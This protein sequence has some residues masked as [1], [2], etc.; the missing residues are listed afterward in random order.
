MAEQTPIG[1][2]T[3]L[4]QEESNC[5]ACQRPDSAD[6]MVQCD[7]CDG[8][9]HYT[10]AGVDASVMNRSWVCGD[11]TSMQED[12]I[13][14]KSGSSRASAASALSVCMS[15]LVERQQLERKRAEIELQ[16]RHL[17]EQQKLIDKVLEGEENGSHRSGVSARSGTIEAAS[18]TS[19]KRLSTPLPP[20]APLASSV[21]RSV[22][23]PGTPRSVAPPMVTIPLAVLKPSASQLPQGTKSEDALLELRNR[24]EQCERR[25]KPTHE[26]LSALQAQL[27]LCR[28]ILEGFQ[29]SAEMCE[30]VGQ[31]EASSTVTEQLPKPAAS[32]PRMEKQTGAIPKA[33]RTLATVP[34]DERIRSKNG[35]EADA[36]GGIDPMNRR[37]PVR[38]PVSHTS[39]AA[40]SQTI[41]ATES[42]PSYMETP[43]KRQALSNYS[44]NANEY[45]SQYCPTTNMY[46]ISREQS[47]NFAHP[48]NSKIPPEVPRE[49]QQVFHAR[50][51]V[52]QIL[53]L[54]KSQYKNK[55][56]ER[57]RDSPT[58]PVEFNKFPLPPRLSENVYQDQVIPPRAPGGPTQQ[59]LA[60]RQSLAKELPRFSGDPA[61]WPIF[62]SSYRYTTEACGFSDGENMLRLQRCLSGSALETV[63][64]RLVLPAAVPQ[65]IETL[66]MRFGRPELLI[67][68]LLR[69]VRD[70]PAPRSDR[71]EG[72]IDFGMA[73]QALCDHIEAANER[74]HLSNPSLLQELVAKLPA[75]QRMMWAGYKRSFQVVDLKTFGDYMTSVVQDASSVVTFEPES[76][77][78]N[79]CDR[80]KNK[81]FVNTHA[82][83]GAVSSVRSINVPTGAAKQ[84]DCAHCSKTGHR[85]RECI[86]F[87]AL[88]VDD[89]WRR[90][91]A[92]GLCQ[93]C[94]FSHGRRACRIRSSCDIEGCQFRH[95]PLL[96]SLRGPPKAPASNALV[97][98][99]HTHRLLTSSTLFR[100]IPVILHGSD[101]SIDTFAFLDEGSDLTLMEHD[102]A[103]SLGLK[104]SPQPLCLRWTGNTS[105]MEK[106]S[107]RI[108]FEIAG[109]GQQKRHKIV[110]A[111]TV[112]CLNLPSQSFQVEEAATKHAHLRGIPVSSYHNAKPKILIGIDNL[113]LALPLKVREGDGTGPIAARTRLGWCVYGPRESGDTEAYNFHVSRCDCDEELH[114]TVKQFFAIEEAGVRPSNIPMSKEEQRA[115]T[116]LE[117]TTR[118][119]ENRF[120]TGLL[121]KEDNV[122]FPNSYTMAVRRLECLERRMDRDPLLKENLHRQMCEYEAKGYA[123]RATKAEIDA[124]DPRR[125]WYLPVGAVINPKKPGKVRVIWDAAAKVDGVSLNSALLKGPDQ[126]S[127]LPAVLFRFRQYRVAVSSDI[128]E[129]FHQIR[130]READKNSQ[131]FLWRACPS[132]KPTI[133]LMDVAT[134]GSTCSPASAQ[135]VKNRNAVQH[136]ELFPEASKAIVHDHYVDDYLSSFGS[137]EE[138]TKVANDVR[139]IHGQGGFKLHNWRSNSGTV[140]EQLGEVPDGTEKQL[141]LIDGSTTERVL[142]MLWS[143]SSDE[144]SFSTQMSDEVQTLIR[145]ATRPTKRQILRCVMTLFDPLGLLSPFIIHGKVLIQDLWREGTDWDEQV[146]DLVYAKWQR[147]IEMIN[148]IAEIRIPRCY[149]PNA[150]RRTYLRAEMHV[151][152]DASEVAY[153]C[154]I[155]LRIFNE[156]GKPQCSLVAAKS[157]V[158][159][160]KPWSIPR[161]EL[162]ACVLG[163]R[164]SKFVKENL[165]VPVSKTVFWTDSRTALSWINADP[166]NYRQFV[167]C[168]VGEILE[169]TSVSDWRWVPSKSNPADEATKWGSGPYFN[170][171]SKWFQGPH[172]LNLLEAD[173]TC[174]KEPVMV[175]VEEMR[176]ST[177][178]HSSSEPTIDFDRF[179]SWDRLQ[180]ATAYVLRFLHNVSKKQPRY[181]GQLQQSE[182]KAAEEVIFKLVQ[183]E[184]YPDEVA[185]LSNKAPNETGQEVIG[186]NS[187]IYQMMPKLDEKGLLREQGRIA[188]VKNVAYNVR[189]PVIL[190]RRHR[191]TELLVHRFH[192]NFRH[193]NAETV[194]NEVRQLYAIP[195]LRL[196]VKK[197]GRECPSCKI[198]RT[199]P[200]IPPMAPL[201]S[202]RLAHHERAFTYTG[203]DYFGPLLVKLG[204]SNVKRW[205]ALFTCLTIRAVHLEIA[206]TLSTESC[207]SCVRRFVGRRGPPAEFFSDNGTNFQGADRVLQHQISQG[208]SATFTSANT[209]WNFIPP[210]AP[211]MGGAWERLVQ[212]VKAAMKE[213]YSEGKLDDEGLQT[214]VVE[215]E[216]VVNSR[217]LT[218]LPLESEET[219][220]LTPNHFLLLSSNGMNQM[221]D[222]DEGP[223]QFSESVRCRILGDSWEQIQHQLNVFWGRWLV[224]YLPVIRRQPKWFSETPSL[225]PGD[226]VMVAEPTRRSGWERGRIVCLKQH[227]D[228]RHRR[229]VV[230]IGDK[231]CVRPVSRL[232]LLDVRKSGAPADSGLH[233]GETVNAETVE[234]A[235]LPSKCNA[236]ASKATQQ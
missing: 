145:M 45:T 25:A 11:C 176:V 107:Q 47:R 124:A 55:T 73:V 180:R 49:Q 36:V 113:R 128:Q 27:E 62:I 5:V 111:R 136:A 164:W 208:L 191:V 56:D 34:E 16:R 201:P 115:L 28:N 53:T 86:A 226:L 39:L 209:K 1:D 198:R 154:V 143:P 40:V 37:W 97:A 135:F 178:H 228:G 88:H 169:H 163:V 85:V 92:L 233:Q 133:Y 106:E 4:E 222:E 130:I 83:E 69:K 32:Q 87:K 166:R 126:L 95:H 42:N 30:R 31:P 76:R 71:L 225:K 173:W 120:E 150:T 155:Y 19:S 77:R 187:C 221:N 203:V 196:M 117:T 199:R 206:Y 78:N 223:R 186:K 193:G 57:M 190:P 122:E 110:N 151:F 119:V 197:V 216:S 129:M 153:S 175:T 91:R 230:K 215:A 59:Q 232:A 165:D 116:I 188:A 66:R 218:Y 60:A 185:A 94:L 204:R 123:H 101:V 158:A 174:R 38:E 74:A 161:L 22:P 70:I 162:Q 12:A 46:E 167:S 156:H 18:P 202:A 160:L 149:F 82:M 72:L 43:G 7:Q 182:L 146:G 194:V 157:K 205:V 170:H 142:G 171:D 24:V 213:A 21:R 217:P 148:H 13:S 93:N 80:P 61:D 102:L 35:S 219:E 189:H 200:M 2:T 29:S 159:P 103:V 41:A 211:H 104:G 17:D 168:R 108:T 68:A 114:D 118:R 26:Q 10:C 109:E 139:Y 3:E 212:S 144:L 67:N 105:R 125:V 54:P 210:G 75:D 112:Q 195:R 9:R 192:R 137:V 99:N 52:T 234:L 172:F 127:S 224:E 15:Q 236:S 89:R 131:R 64:S 50:P 20:G 207:I 6:N 184:Q 140:L 220:A 152:V 181:S 235:T 179:S 134:F 65:V 141:N 227:A 121:W 177:Q 51:G 44:I 183:R 48:G 98:E 23:A 33:G 147:W 8:W 58:Y 79:P 229:A 96:H 90:V 214:L 100:I 231:T 138:A 84:F 63:R 132:E 14:L 81:A